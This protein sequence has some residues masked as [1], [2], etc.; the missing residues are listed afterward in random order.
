MPTTSSKS[1]STSIFIFL[2]PIVFILGLGAGYLIWGNRAAADTQNSSYILNLADDDASIGPAD[3]PITIV[4]FS[5]YQ[6]PYCKK[7]Y[8]D[9]FSRLLSDY[10]NQIRFVYRDFPLYQIHPGAEPAAEAAECAGD[11][12]AY[13]Q[14]HNALFSNKYD[15]TSDGFIQYATELG[16]D[17]NS[18]AS[19]M[20]S[21]THQSEVIKDL[22]DAI[23]I[24][25]QSTP[26][27]FS[28]G[29]QVVGAQPY[30]TF[31]NIIDQLLAGGNSQ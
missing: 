31:K 14:Y 20:S 12:N 2:I 24:G 18:F 7:W 22:Q 9:V 21:A 1:K 16:L 28:N 13:W 26:T 29:F 27:F 17:T 5:D 4:E 23:N 25:V 15:L 11:Q 10:P 19:C 30:E 3:A 8:D 6:C